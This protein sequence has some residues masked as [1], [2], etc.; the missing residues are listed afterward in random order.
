VPFLQSWSENS[1]NTF[2]A[3]SGVIPP[4]LAVL[5]QLLLPVLMRALS[6]RH[7]ATTRTK[8]AAFLLTLTSLTAFRLDH[9]VRKM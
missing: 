3:F 5:L 8:C 9:A 6:R 2:S 7:G 1:P 4:I